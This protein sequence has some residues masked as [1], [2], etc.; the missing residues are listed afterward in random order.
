MRE[1]SSP[2]DDEEWRR[3]WTLSYEDRRALTAALWCGEH[4]WFRSANVVALERYRSPDEWRRICAFFW[5]R[6]R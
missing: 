4:R 5:P 1:G 2:P 6:R 3:Q